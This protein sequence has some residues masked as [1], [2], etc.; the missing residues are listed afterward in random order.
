[1]HLVAVKPAPAEA[2]LALGVAPEGWIYV[3]SNPA[4]TTYSDHGGSSEDFATRLVVMLDAS[5]QAQHPLR[6]GGHP[7]AITKSDGYTSVEL[8]LGAKRYLVVQVPPQLSLN[9]QQLTQLAGSA[10]VRSGAV[11]AQG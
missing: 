3:D 8:V 9:Q 5:G 6:I 2:K 7:A 1:V 11:A 4:S 10:T